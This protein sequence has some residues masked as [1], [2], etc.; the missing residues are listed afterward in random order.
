[1]Q[2]DLSEAWRIR[3]FASQLRGTRMEVT[4]TA[5]KILPCHLPEQPT[6]IST[7]PATSMDPPIAMYN[8]E[9]IYKVMLRNLPARCRVDEL[10]QAIQDLGFDVLYRTYNMPL[11]RTTRMNRGYAFVTFDRLDVARAFFYAINGYRF[12]SRLGSK[13]VVAEEPELQR[14]F[15]R[16]GHMDRLANCM[17]D[18]L[19]LPPGITV[20]CCMTL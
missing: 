17:E 10:K 12:P 4:L 18:V 16:D 5:G 1:M 7:R 20:L 15:S 8:E 14:V 2:A 11:K 13:M 19:R 6:Q 3:A 9:G